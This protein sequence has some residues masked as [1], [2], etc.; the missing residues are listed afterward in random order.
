MKILSPAGNFQSLKMAIANGADEVYLGINSFNARNNIAGFE[1]DTLK[2]AVDYAHVFGVKV[3]LAINILFSDDQ[4]QEALS[5]LVEAYNMGVD[6]FIIQD[7]GLASLVY[8]NYPQIELHA[9]TQMAIHNLEGVRFIEKL[10]FKRVVL[11]RETPLSE[12]RRIKQNSNIEIEYFV[13][14][15]LCV[16]FSGNCYIS[17]YLCGASGNLGKCKQLCRLPYTLE[18]DNKIIKR[19][20]L[21]SAKDFNMSSKLKDLKEAGVDVLKI[22]GR[23]R[24]PFYVGATTR[25]YRKALDGEKL[26]Q[27][28]LKLSFNRHYTPGYFEGNG[29]IISDFASHIGLQVGKVK[30]VVLGKR[31][32]E[33]Y[34][35]S[36]RELSS[37]SSF[38]FFDGKNETNVISAY[39]L[40]K[41]NKNE[42]VLTTTQNVKT[43]VGVNLIQ[44]DELEQKMLSQNAKRKI[45]V[46]INAC[47][48]KN[49]KAT[50]SFNQEQF[51][52]E[53]VE[54]LPAQNQPIKLEDIVSNFNKSDLFEANVNIEKLE[55]VF[56]TKKQLNEFRRQVFD[57]AF[58]VLTKKFERNESIV[59]IDLNYKPQNFEDFEIVESYKYLPHSKN[60]IYSPEIYDENDIKLFMSEC[61]KHGKVPYLDLVNFA[62]EADINLIR[63]LITNTG[64][65][66]VANNY[67]ALELECEKVAGAGL[68]VYNSM[69]AKVL[70]LK[71]LTAESDVGS[72]IN[73]PYM[74]LK[75]CP[76][77]SHLNADCKNCPYKQGYTYKME[78]G[79]TF[80]LERK[81][82]STCTFFLVD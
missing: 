34:F 23:A 73:Y 80:R 41:L 49:V 65:K 46:S 68:N 53:G 17:S 6:A 35:L 70:G 44:D 32:N 42:Y 71:L 2:E 43:G 61:E 64:I 25:E 37:K 31:F 7:I 24:R 20:Y 19:G 29:K 59:E 58:N 60:I 62:L 40:K 51:E 82:L 33:V 8:E 3:L 63:N 72:R 21:L 36:D 28:N 78:N 16:C 50:I 18:K 57:F 27:N 47:V 76:M 30:K 69:S 45:D 77:K 81:K 67:Y 26:D 66:V 79:K 11:A 54:C 52:I 1:K 38:K 4:L 56:L 55:N 15:A 22:E 75:H 5:T 12:I 13:Q 39:D 9:S 14:G 10:G 48:R 74:T